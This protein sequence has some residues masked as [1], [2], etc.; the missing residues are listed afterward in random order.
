[1]ELLGGILGS[2][3][4]VLQLLRVVF[5][6]GEGRQ[7]FGSFSVAISK[8]QPLLLSHTSHTLVELLLLLLLQLFTDSLIA[9]HIFTLAIAFTGMEMR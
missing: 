3:G 2:E 9:N 4:L 6:E 7:I 5:V 8:F 1:M